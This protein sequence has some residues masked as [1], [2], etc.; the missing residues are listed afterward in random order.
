M[1]KKVS[2]FWF[3][4]DLRLDDNVGFLEALKGDYPVLPLFIFDKD[5]LDKL[6]ENDARVTF[7]F[8]TLQE[9]RKELQ[10][11]YDSSLAM[12]HDTPEK[13]F[14]SLVKDYQIQEVFTNRDYEPYAKERDTSIKEL[15][16]KN[17]ISFNTY[18]DQVIFEKDEVVKKDGDPYLVY[19]PYK[20]TWKE[21][22]KDHT[23]KI[24]YTSQ[25]LDN[26]VKNTRLPNVSLS[27]MGFKKSSIS[28]PEYD[29]SPT[30]IENYNDTR[31][32]PAKDGTSNL[33]P[34]LR[35]GTV[36]IRKIYKK[37]IDAKDE[38]F[39]NELIWRE[40]FMQI[41][42]HFPETVNNAFKKKY[43]R[44][45][46][47]NNE[48]E[49][50]KWK[51]G[52]TGYPLVDAGMRQLNETGLMHNRVRMVVGSFLC[53]HLLIDW[54]WGEAYFAEK[55]LDY[56]MSSNVGNWQWV[57]G[58]GVDAAPYFR[59]F[60]PTTQIDKFDKNKTYINHWVKEY[61]TNKYPEKMVDHKE[62]RERCLN[63]YK[64]ALN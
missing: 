24:H 40:F 29:T 11:D 36:G 63:A 26:T 1:S 25:H 17:N 51:T 53:K 15:L 5:I 10:D 60:N 52:T 38:T 47:R 30:L 44:I 39:W 22:F 64:S 3:R 19:T 61:N 13:V 35:F 62:A 34:H 55:L 41:L 43:D 27:E 50:E 7:I 31:N 2:I 32:F 42:Y 59:I 49:F 37:A 4:R 8:E 23:L 6:P 14:K 21:N 18:K 16:S 48:D 12:F 58:S 9:M 45:E 33:S 28:F 20:N 46:W 56:E 57:A 54:R